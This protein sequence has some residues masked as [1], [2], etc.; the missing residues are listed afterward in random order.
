MSDIFRDPMWQFVAVLLAI[1][2]ILV[3]ISL[4]LK[5]RRRKILSYEIVSRTPLLSMEE[6]IKGTL[7][8]LYDGQPVERV[9]LI[10]VK[11][12][13]S[14]NVP[15]LSTEYERP[16]SL[17]LGEE[18]R[19]LTAEVSKT[20]PDSLKA[21]VTIEENK[22]VL[23]KTLLNGGD[24]VTLKMLVSK[25]GRKINVDGRIIGV[26]EIS[27]RRERFVPYIIAFVVGMAIY[28]IGVF[29]EPPLES[30]SWMKYVSMFLGLGLSMLGMFGMP[31]YR[32]I[33]RRVL[34]L[35]EE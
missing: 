20:Y 18:A 24:S 11:I 14:G 5:Q 26:K 9:H 13:N 3:S 29:Y 6:E 16:I 21:S 31:K 15:I 30:L 25:Y 19:V 32:K 17:S 28:T 7:K 27:Q 22:I 2:A 12:I 23:A 33:F 35:I 34:K 8:I 10:V 1:I 4:Y